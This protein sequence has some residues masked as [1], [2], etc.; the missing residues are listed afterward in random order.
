[1]EC[2]VCYEK[3]NK[4][5]HKEVQCFHCEKSSCSSC[6]QRY[7]V[8]TTTDPKCLH[9]NI[10]WDRRFMINNLTKK[11]CNTDYRHYRRSMIYERNK[12]FLPTISSILGEK[13]KL[14]ELDNQIVDFKKQL[15]ILMEE[16]GRQFMNIINLEENFIQGREV[17]I[18][19]KKNNIN[20]R[21]C[22]TENCLGFL[23][24]DGICPICK[25][26]T[27]LSC[28][29]KIDDNKETHECKKEDKEQWE[30]LKKTTKPCPSCQVRIFKI[31]GCDQ[32]WCTNCHNAFSWSRGTIEKGTIHN[33]HYYDWV[34]NNEQIE[35]TENI[36]EGE[37][38]ENILPDLYRLRSILLIKK[39]HPKEIGKVMDIHRHLIHLKEIEIPKL[40]GY[41]GRYYGGNYDH[42]EENSYRRRILPYLYK[43][44][45]NEKDSKKGLEKFDYRVHCDIEFSHIL[46][47]YITEQ[48]YLINI[49]YYKEDY[50]YN[51]F[52]KDV[53][54]NQKFFLNGI[55]NFEEEYK[56]KYNRLSS[57]IEYLC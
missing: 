16:R 5:N 25:Y 14:K 7:L 32:M 21:P 9:C 40:L 49:I 47:T 23:G 12:C 44:I 20:N 6:I 39:F 45:Y 27:C 24:G 13:E 51:S 35:R 18:E 19:N 56:R 36:N 42:N 33:P 29:I 26:K 48:T 30:Y 28:N 2:S 38:N 15:E 4:Q 43:L 55:Y 10:K 53:E 37:C 54:K 34:F 17:N 57:L 41:I 50:T 52:L 8:E 1:M 11:F 46:E 31:S 3:Y 22:I